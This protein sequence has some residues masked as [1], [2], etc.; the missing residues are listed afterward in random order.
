MAKIITFLSNQKQCGK[1]TI[2]FN[3]AN[4]LSHQNKKILLVNLELDPTKFLKCF[5]KLPKI[6]NINQYFSCLTYAKHYQIMFI[7]NHASIHK[8]APTMIDYQKSLIK[9]IRAWSKLFDVII[10]DGNSI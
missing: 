10:L 6:K 1:T 4:I 3:F 8:T 5:S 2:A 7:T 9:Q